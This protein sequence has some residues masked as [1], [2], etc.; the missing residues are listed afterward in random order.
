MQAK[1]RGD[2]KTLYRFDL[3]EQLLS[4]YEVSNWYVSSHPDSIFVTG[5][6]AARPATDRRY[7]LRNNEFAVHHLDGSTERRIFTEAAEIRETLEG[8]FRLILPETPELDAALSK[9]TTQA[10]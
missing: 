2:W 10:G 9:L 8:A 4:D 3:Q 5:L 1:I 7:A 6:M